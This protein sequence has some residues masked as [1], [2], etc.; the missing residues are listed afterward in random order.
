MTVLEELWYGNIYPQGTILNEN[1]QFKHLLSLI[2][3]NR[4]KLSDTLTDQQKELLEKYDD[5]VNEMHAL[6]EQAAFQYG[7]SL[8]I[9]LMMECLEIRITKEE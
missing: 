9:R 6:A 7:V 4:D 5:V 1:L 8:G 2:G 3:R